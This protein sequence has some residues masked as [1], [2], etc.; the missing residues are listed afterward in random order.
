MKI[1]QIEL[2]DAERK[3]LDHGYKHGKTASYRKRCHII[4]LKSD[5]R[6]AKD[7]AQITDTNI[8]SVY[9]WLNRYDAEGIQGLQTK[10]GQ[11][12]PRILDKQHEQIVKDCISEERQLSPSW[13]TTTTNRQTISQMTLKRFFKTLVT[14]I[15][16]SVKDK[17][18][19][20]SLKEYQV[21]KEHN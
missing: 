9:N 15:N 11:G 2:T 3:A 18:T 12:R 13:Q 19:M 1:R 17:R 7:I 5:G 20:P 10:A 21:R 8:Q 6:I 16:V 4:L 14:P